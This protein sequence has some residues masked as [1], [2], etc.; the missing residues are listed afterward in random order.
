MV[1][2]GAFQVLCDLLKAEGN[3]EQW[4][5]AVDSMLALGHNMHVQQVPRHRRRYSNIPPQL[6][7]K[8]FSR[9][10]C[11]FRDLSLSEP[12]LAKAQGVAGDTGDTVEHAHCRYMDTDFH[13]FDLTL[14]LHSPLGR[15]VKVQA[16][17]STLM[18]ESDVFRVMLAGSY[19]ES[20]CGEVHIH[21]ISP[22]GFLSLLHHMYGCGWR[23]KEVLKMAVASWG[24]EGGW[25]EE[26]MDSGG[27]MGMG[28]E[29]NAVAVQPDLLSKTT[30]ILLGEIA[31]ACPDKEER[32]R[33]KHCLQVL[34][35]AGRFL[36]PDLVT[37]SEHAAAKSLQPGNVVAMFHFAQLHQCFCLAESCIRVLV[38][39]P[40]LQLRTQV[41]KEL[42][43]STEGD[44]A[45][46]IILLF[47]TATDF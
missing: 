7:P 47:L 12:S 34:V 18:E 31:A 20:S 37:L 44:A 42:V 16:H 15:E 24:R 23:C 36:L 25:N 9:L 27:G 21:S 3:T 39:I 8:K 17:K 29:E 6:Q 22:C 43:T 14:I 35:C 4:E 28:M 1:D 2:Y 5:M 33:T 32:D 11:S 13:P 19:K 10:D 45:L 41:F 38:T 46:Q 40:H 30:T 26:R